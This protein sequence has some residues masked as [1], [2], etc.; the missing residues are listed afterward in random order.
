[1]NDYIK[2]RNLAVYIVTQN[3]DIS[4]H[5]INRILS[6]REHFEKMVLVT[7]NS[8]NVDKDHL[9]VNSFP[10]PTGILRFLGLNKIKKIIDKSIFFP[11]PNILYVWAVIKRLKP[12]I[13]SDLKK[14]KRVC[15]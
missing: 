14:N 2:K 10:N 11:S 6:L 3:Q 12:Y 13:R 4:N 8:T 15:I 5:R 9:V 7:K 1:M